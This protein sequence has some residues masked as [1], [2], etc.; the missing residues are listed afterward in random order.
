MNLKTFIQILKKNAVQLT[1]KFA[2]FI[3]NINKLNLFFSRLTKVLNKRYKV[4]SK[5]ISVKHFM[6]LFAV[7]FV[8]MFGISVSFPAVPVIEQEVTPEVIVEAPQ[9]E[10]ISFVQPA[11]AAPEIPVELPIL[12]LSGIRQRI[13]TQMRQINEPVVYG[14][15]VLYS[16]GNA[17][18]IDGP[19]LTRL[20]L[21]SIDTG[22]EIEIATS[23]IRFGEIYEGRI[24]SSWIVWLDTNQMGTNHIYA[25]NRETGEVIPVSRDSKNRPQLALWGDY[26]VWTG[27]VE[28]GLDNMYLFRLSSGEIIQIESFDNPTFG[29]ASPSIS[30]GLLVWGY[31]HDTN[32]DEKGLI[33]FLDLNNKDPFAQE[34]ETFQMPTAEQ[35]LDEAPDL[36]VTEIYTETFAVYPVTNGNAIAYLTHLNPAKASLKLTLDQGNSAITVAEN[37]GRFFG[38]G[39]DFIVYTQQGHIKIF[40]WDRKQYADLTVSGEPAK[41]SEHTASEDSI[42]WFDMTDPNRSQD[43]V[44]V[45]KIIS[46]MIE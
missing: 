33:R 26:L 46:Q 28:S 23:Q 20:M 11:L 1:D 29:T 34:T 39:N 27:Q 18:S 22:E 6:A 42:V 38:L 2:L 37:V 45:S 16:A 24:N 36:G 32:P 35:N 40:F 12:D 31:P 41:L 8:I 14:N 43:E 19:V 10:V 7:S 25:M 9:Q 30:G 4:K 15:Y 17:T 21:Y 5:T 13:S 3:S 44:N